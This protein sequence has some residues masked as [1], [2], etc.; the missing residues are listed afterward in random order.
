MHANGTFERYK[1]RMVAK[2]F[3][4]TE[5]LDY[6]DT[7][8]PVIKMTT[9]RVLLAMVVVHKWPLFQLDLN[10]TFLYGDLNEEVYMKPPPSLAL[11]HLDLVCQLKKSLNGLK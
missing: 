9:I 10:T 4:Q 6:M 5:G 2:G 3:T 8:S 7:F 11:S 1:A